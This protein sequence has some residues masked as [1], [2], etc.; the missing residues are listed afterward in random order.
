MSRISMVLAAVA[1][2]AVVSTG[3]QAFDDFGGMFVDLYGGAALPG[4][5]SYDG[6]DY[7]MHWGGA[8]GAAVGVQTPVEGLALKLDLMASGADYVGYEYY[9]IG[10]ENVSLMAVGEYA[11][12]VTDGLELYG[13]LG[14]GGVLVYYYD[15]DY[16]GVGAGYQA[17]LGGRAALSENVSLFGEVKYLSTFSDVDTNGYDIRY[18]TTNVLSGLRFSFD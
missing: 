16:S 15:T 5:S 1:M 14:L 18:P 7:D 6:T 2:A 10:V 9:D 11:V 13:S 3:A 12:P 17:A 8:I 4:V